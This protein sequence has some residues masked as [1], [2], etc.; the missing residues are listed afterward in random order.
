MAVPS[1]M[2]WVVA[3]LVV[4]VLEILSERVLGSVMLSAIFGTALILVVLFLA[5][6]VVCWSFLRIERASR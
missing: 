3:G 2:R 5:V 1:L 6:T 4:A